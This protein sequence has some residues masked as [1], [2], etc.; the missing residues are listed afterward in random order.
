MTESRWTAVVFKVLRC[1]KKNP[2][3]LG[4][5]VPSNEFS[6]NAAIIEIDKVNV[7]M[8]NLLV[9]I[10]IGQLTGQDIFC[11]FFSTQCCRAIP[12]TTILLQTVLWH[13][14]RVDFLI[15]SVALKLRLSFIALF[16]NQ[17]VSQQ[18]AL[19][20]LALYQLFISNVWMSMLLLL[21]FHFSA[22]Y[23]LFI[24]LFFSFCLWVSRENVISWILNGF[25]HSNK[26]VIRSFVQSVCHT[27]RIPNYL[28]AIPKLIYRTKL[29]ATR[30]VFLCAIEMIKAIFQNSGPNRWLDNLIWN[31]VSRSLNSARKIAKTNNSL[32][33]RSLCCCC[34][35]FLSIYYIFIVHLSLL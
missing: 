15:D 21:F 32:L 24:S 20:A 30:V 23:H 1:K 6:G 33:G 8:E 25:H 2:K 12:L 5:C 10:F 27:Q 18:S 31:L 9:F 4:L 34:C 26:I 13:K 35:H 14:L 29:S 3:P 11:S 22:L 7:Q 19:M 16:F 28:T 17:I